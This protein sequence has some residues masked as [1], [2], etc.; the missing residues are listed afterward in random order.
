[1]VVYRLSSLR[2]SNK[3]LRL[4]RRLA[5]DY[6]DRRLVKCVFEKVMQRKDR[7]V[8]K[9]FSQKRFRNELTED[10]ARK[11]KVEATNVYIDV[12]TTPSVPHTYAREA[13]NSIT[14]VS[15]GV[16][17]RGI[18]RLSITELP[19]V[20]SITGFTDVL[21]ST[22]SRSTEARSDGPFRRSLARKT[23]VSASPSE[24]GLPAGPWLANWP[25]T[26]SHIYLRTGLGS[27]PPH[28]SIAR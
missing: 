24:G 17:G 22:R 1:M 11:A 6:N 28:T 21:E 14:L 15:A 9:I 10:I 27:P 7:V 18:K 5:E 13:L 8:E 12:P 26:A 4:A 2:P 25:P 19:L 3:K 16:A 23:S 20:G